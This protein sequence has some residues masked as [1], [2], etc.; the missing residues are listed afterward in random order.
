MGYKSGQPS[1]TDISAS[2]YVSRND[3]FIRDASMGF[4]ANTPSLIP[5]G[6]C[7]ISHF[8]C[9]LRYE[10][11]DDEDNCQRGCMLYFR[12]CTSV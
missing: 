6:E 7:T 12:G 3:Q 4:P 2:L 5:Y 1:D 10:A 11:F 8:K 9:I